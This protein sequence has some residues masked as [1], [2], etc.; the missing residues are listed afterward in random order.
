MAERNFWNFNNL[1]TRKGT[2]ETNPQSVRLPSLRTL[3]GFFTYKTSNHAISRYF[4]A[5]GSN[6]L[7]Y[8]VVHKVSFSSASIKRVATNEKGEEIA[9]SQLIELLKAPNEDQGEIEFREAINESLLLCGNAFVRFIRGIGAG[10]ELTVLNPQC[11]ELITNRAGELAYYQY[12]EPT[13]GSLIKITDLDEILHI[14]TTNTVSTDKIWINW[15]LSPLQAGWI[16]VQSSNEKF[17]A[18][19]SIFKNRGIIGILTNKSDRPMLKDERERMQKEFDA[20]AGGSDKFNKIKI[21]TVDLQYIQT[22]MSPTDLQLL[23]GII[24]SLRHICSI[25]GVSSILFN[26]NENSSYNNIV[27]ARKDAYTE[28][29]I[30]LAN[31]VDKELS[32]FLNKHLGTN[33]TLKADLNSIEVLKA[34]TNEVAQSLNALNP[35]IATRVLEQLTINEIRSLLP[36]IEDIEGGDQIAGKGK[37][38]GKEE[39]NQGGN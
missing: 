25:Y 3:N 21:S 16:V 33:E 7:V 14:K 34:S 12:T 1:F 9:N 11:M 24:S 31:K 13:T 30:P 15:G 10:Y 28:S 35:Q 26:D 6:P 27:E 4:E 19:A 23:D 18:E 38:N 37:S 22:G 17:S 36:K 29:Y 20:E 2:L 5:Y 32:K 8:Q 39:T